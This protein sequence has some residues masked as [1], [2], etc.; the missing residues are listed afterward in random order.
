MKKIILAVCLIAVASNVLALTQEETGWYHKGWTQ[1]Q[2][3]KDDLECR[4]EAAKL[5]GNSSGP[6]WIMAARKKRELL[7]LCMQSRGYQLTPIKLSE[8][9]NTVGP[10][11]KSAP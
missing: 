1:A 8:S 4:Y 9:V 5:T 7:D 3:E 10:L 2:Y 11:E 6:N